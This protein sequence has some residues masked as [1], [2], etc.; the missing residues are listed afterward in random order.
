MMFE[1]PSASARRRDAGVAQSFKFLPHRTA[2]LTYVE[3]GVP[4][5][6][7]SDLQGLAHP[8]ARGWLVYSRPLYRPEG[9]LSHHF[10]PTSS[11]GWPHLRRLCLN[12]ISFLLYLSLGVQYPAS[13]TTWRADHPRRTIAVPEGFRHAAGPW[14]PRFRRM[15]LLGSATGVHERQSANFVQACVSFGSG[16]CMA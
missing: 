5:A 6:A 13:G 3:T 14:Q 4:I 1:N 8:P 12:V 16:Y 15:L 2:R 7:A 9:V 10:S 11:W